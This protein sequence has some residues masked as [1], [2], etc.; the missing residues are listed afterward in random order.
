[1]T[2][3]QLKDA[4]GRVGADVKRNAM[5]IKSVNSRVGKLGS[6]VDGIA[7]VNRVQSKQIGKVQKLIQLDAALDFAQGISF[8]G[9]DLALDPY[10][11]FRGAVKSGMVGD[12]K[13][14]AGNPFLV[15]AIGL[16]LNRPTVLGRFLSDN[17]S[18]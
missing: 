16:V 12:A 2:Q 1:V 8:D 18:E 11:L 5:G 7:T 4:L 6:R 3:K 10:H 9:G 17:T 15:G 13:G 14:A